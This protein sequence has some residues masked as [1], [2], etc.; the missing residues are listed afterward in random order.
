MFSFLG[1]TILDRTEYC[2]WLHLHTATFSLEPPNCKVAKP[3]N[4]LHRW[5]RNIIIPFCLPNV[6][7]KPYRLLKHL[8]LLAPTKL[9]LSF[10]LTKAKQQPG[11][12]GVKKREH[13][14]SV[15]K[16]R[17]VQEMWSPN[18]LLKLIYEPKSLSSGGNKNPFNYLICT[19]VFVTLF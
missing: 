10:G 13:P 9:Q 5:M 12:C 17:G 4:R 16:E 8:V 3:R 7:R 18:Q 1:I 6:A 2:R 11:W 15:V 19:S 14:S